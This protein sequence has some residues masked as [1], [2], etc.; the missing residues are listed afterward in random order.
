MLKKLNLKKILWI[1]IFLLFPGTLPAGGV[2]PVGR[3]EYDFVYDRLERVEALSLDRFD[4]QL[5]PYRLDREA[6]RWGPF[7]SL[8]E[9]PGRSLGLFAFV[10]EDFRSAKEASAH[11]WEAFR[12]GIVARPHERVFVYGNFLLD[13]C[14]A[15]DPA[16][17]GKKWRGLAGGVESAFMHVRFGMLEGMLGRFASFWGPRHSLVLSPGASMD[18][19]AYTIRWG[20]LSLSYRLARLDGLNPDTDSVDQFEN[21]YFAGHRLDV[22]ISKRV[23]LGVFETMIFGGPGR[24]ID[25]YYLNPIIFFHSSQINEGMNDNTFLGFDFSVKPREGC[26]IYGQLL[27][28][29]FQVDSREPGDKEPDQYGILAGAYVADVLPSFDMKAEY[30]R[31]TNWSFNQALQRNRY[32]YEGSLIGGALGNDYDQTRFWF[33]KW[34]GDDMAA[35][36]SLSYVRQGEGEVTEEFTQPWLLATGAYSEEFP[37]GV[38]EKTFTASMSLQGFVENHFFFSLEAGADWHRNYRHISG[39][40]RTLPFI[41]L[42][43]SSFIT[44]FVDIE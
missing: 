22:H 23:R 42:K 33:I 28:D 14:R 39:D 4:Y 44:S 7:E 35:S 11:G 2:L 13:E 37:T 18:G 34:F 24:Q 25:L 17:T 6:F 9:I 29:D 12:G 43:L 26:N 19:F 40:S 31:V 8:R 30:T 36:L 32:L 38:V 41:H 3:M 15:D 21:R 20:R 27:V 10:S 5:G 1:I 16:Y